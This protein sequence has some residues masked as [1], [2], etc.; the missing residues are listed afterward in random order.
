MHPFVFFSLALCSLS[1]ASFAEASKTLRG[2]SVDLIHRDSPLS[3]FY[4]PSLTPSERIK[5]AA[6]RSISRINRVAHTL[7]E[8]KSPETILIPENGEY[9]MR[10]HIGYPPVERLA[11]VD[12]GSDLIWVQCSPCANC[13][14][15]DTPLYEPLKSSTFNPL[16]CGSQ[17]CLYFPPRLRRCGNSGECIYVYQ[18]VEQSFTA[19]LLGT[20]TINLGSKVENQTVNFPNSVFG[21]G[22]YNNLSFPT[23]DKV[24][25]LVGLGPGPLSLVSQIGDQI[26]Y[27]FSYCL[28]PF[29]SNSTSKLRFGT[30]AAITGNGVVSTP[31]IIKPNLPTFYFLNLESVTIGQKVVQTGQTD[32]NIIIDSG[33]VLT[34]ID[35]TFY[36]NFVASLQEALTVEA[37]QDLPFPFNFCF[38][39]RENMAFPDIAFQ[40]TGARVSLNPKNLFLWVEDRDIL[41]LAVVPRALSTGISIFGNIAQIDFQVEYD[42]QGKKVSFAPTDCTKI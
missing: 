25:G 38:P 16:S 29:S 5:N 22:L 28:L 41:C 11:I 2:F 14:P 3:P 36:S 13:F 9:L 19:G 34:Y 31:L 4:N 26:G 6:L 23:S 33:T 8:N 1:I 21:C 10:F 12:T 20:E 35:Q 39:Y 18:Y 17:P 37:T 42:L 15:Q 32:G 30:E 40:F 27:K 24:T 7:D